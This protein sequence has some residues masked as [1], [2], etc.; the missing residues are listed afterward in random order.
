MVGPDSWGI[1]GNPVSHS[2]TPRMFSIVGSYLELEA[3]QIFVESSSIEDFLEKTS[4]IKGDIWISCTSPLKHLVPSLPG[5]RSSG[6]VDGLN[7]LMRARGFWWGA[8][9]DGPGFVSACRYIGVEP[10]IATLRIRGGGS[11]ARSIAAAWASEG[12]L[13]ISETGRRPLASGPWDGSILETG[14]ADLAVDLDVLPGGGLSADLE[15]DI[16][17]SISYDE[18]ASVDEFAIV[19]LAAQH[20]HAWGSLFLPSRGEELPSLEDLLSRL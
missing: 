20:I 8:N 18:G 14:K 2:F 10:S 19:M 17:I 7:Q 3:K 1:A 4:Q 13:I 15:G 11:T 9:T 12:G 16:Q 5:L 6:A